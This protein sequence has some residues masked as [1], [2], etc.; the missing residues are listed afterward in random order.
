MNAL[1]A[2]SECIHHKYT[3]LELR[4]CNLRNSDLAWALLAACSQLTELRLREIP[5]LTSL[6][7]L[8]QLPNL[9][10]LHLELVK[11]TDLSVL[12]KLPKL[13]HLYLNGFNC[14]TLA[15]LEELP[16]LELLYLRNIYDKN[17]EDDFSFFTS[18]VNLYEL[19]II[20]E[21]LGNIDFLP[22]LKKLKKLLLNGNALDDISPISQLENLTYLDIS[23]NHI[24]DFSPLLACKKLTYI[25]A[26]DNKFTSLP[27]MS[28]FEELTFLDV[29]KCR[30]SDLSPL[31]ALPLLERLY[32]YDNP[33]KVRP[34]ALIIHFLGQVQDKNP[35]IKEFLRQREPPQIE[36][37]WQL[38]VT[39]QAENIF[40][41]E[42][43]AIAADWT[44][45][46]IRVY[47]KF[48]D[49]HL[50]EG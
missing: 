12:Q 20:Y 15:I 30:I 48:A 41:A 14:N 9:E 19:G 26:F 42:Q 2:I 28:N 49:R 13:R 6:K 45:E 22:P 17:R 5:K 35:P 47:T 36:Q 1:Q 31:M 25:S 38:W 34:P 43:L 39:G 10:I 4:K 16:Q 29:S 37:I 44:E 33:I 18:L 24:T 8:E 11:V 32:T 21:A 50:R 23:Y 27:D 3:V 40:L 46:E 7:I